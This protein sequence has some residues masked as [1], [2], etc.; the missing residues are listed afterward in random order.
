M[1]LLTDEIKSILPELY[2]QEHNPDAVAVVKFF[3]PWSSWSWYGVEFDGVDLF[4][5][6]VKGHEVE[7]GYFSLSELEKLRGPGGLKIERDL[8]FRPVPVKTLQQ[9]LSV[10]M[11][12]EF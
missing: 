9:A 12:I 5:G 7:L 4:F 3:T 6:L 1:R 11:E 8:Y 2:S 10:N